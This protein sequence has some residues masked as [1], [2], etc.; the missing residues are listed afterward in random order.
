MSLRR[1]EMCDRLSA[2]ASEDELDVGDVAQSVSMGFA[3]AVAALAG[4]PARDTRRPGRAESGQILA[5]SLSTNP[6]GLGN[7]VQE[8]EAGQDG[9]PLRS[10]LYRYI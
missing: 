6:D 10:Y 3:P 4:V 7:Q 8:L 2:P 9:S 1:W 5:A